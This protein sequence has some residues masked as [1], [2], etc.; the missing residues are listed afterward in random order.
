M[1]V[2]LESEIKN[3]SK[4]LKSLQSTLANKQKQLEA[5]KNNNKKTSSATLFNNKEVLLQFL[6]HE[7]FCNDTYVLQN[8]FRDGYKVPK[9]AKCALYFMKSSDAPLINF[10]FTLI[11]EKDNG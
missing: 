10:D 11:M 3:I 8:G 2:D 7:P 4:Q 5:E 9:C 6:Q 1:S